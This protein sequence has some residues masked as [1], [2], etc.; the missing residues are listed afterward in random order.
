MTPQR[1]AIPKRERSVQEWAQL[2]GTV[3]SVHLVMCE[4]YFGWSDARLW[5]FGSP[6]EREVFNAVLLEQIREVEYFCAPFAYMQWL[7]VS[8]GLEAPLQTVEFCASNIGEIHRHLEQKGV[9]IANADEVSSRTWRGLLN[10]RACRIWSG[11][12][13]F[14]LLCTCILYGKGHLPSGWS[15]G[16]GALAASMVFLPV[17]VGLVRDLRSGR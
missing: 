10:T 16:L 4:K 6:G 17:L 13:L 2:S 12:W 7:R 11:S 1:I 5:T 9:P 8:W 15:M 3:R 14:G